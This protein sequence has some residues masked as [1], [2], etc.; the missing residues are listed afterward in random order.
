MG[1]KQ[2][3]RRSIAC[4]FPAKAVYDLPT[5]ELLIEMLRL[6]PMLRRLGDFETKRDIPSASTFSRAFADFAASGLGDAVHLWGAPKEIHASLNRF[7]LGR[8]VNLSLS[9]PKCYSN[10]VFNNENTEICK[11]LRRERRT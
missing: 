10:A 6:L 1:H 5:T 4:A 11:S 9:R 8:G 3:D 7:C 2:L